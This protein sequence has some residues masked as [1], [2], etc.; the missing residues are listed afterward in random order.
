[1][2]P[3]RCWSAGELG[4]DQWFASRLFERTLDEL[5]GSPN[6]NPVGDCGNLAVLTDELPKNSLLAA[7]KRCLWC[8]TVDT[9]VDLQRAKIEFFCS[10]RMSIRAT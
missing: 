10:P 2:R 7:I 6:Q 5:A 9:H 3:G 8:T 4:G 1:M